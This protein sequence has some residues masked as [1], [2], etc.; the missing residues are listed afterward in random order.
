MLAE[1]YR[2]HSARVVATQSTQ[3]R[4]LRNRHTCAVAPKNAD[5]TRVTRTAAREGE[6]LQLVRADPFGDDFSLVGVDRGE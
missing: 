5:S 1:V 4:T 2:E 6:R 3:I